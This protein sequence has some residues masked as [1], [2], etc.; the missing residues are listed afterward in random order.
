MSTAERIKDILKAEVDGY[1]RL[2]SLLQQE[3]ERLIT[4][5]ASE[6]ENLAKEKDTVIMAL[7]L[8]DDERRRLI[9]MFESET[10]TGPGL[11]LSMLSEI[12]G[13]RSLAELRAGLV[14]LVQAVSELND[15]NRVLI[16]R[17][18]SVVRNALSFLGVV[19]AVPQ[20]G[21]AGSIS[22]EA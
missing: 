6:I 20:Q 1:R 21:K 5:H 12:T 4:F 2:L 11:T 3:R 8:L 16:E 19:G 14:S 9:S 17:S 18:S 13:D 7:R 10:G 15:F 22:R